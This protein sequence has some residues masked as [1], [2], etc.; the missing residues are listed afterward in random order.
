MKSVF[1]SQSEQESH[2]C[3]HHAREKKK[4]LVKNMFEEILS[5][6]KKTK[7]PNKQTKKP[8]LN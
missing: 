7:K 4:K 5:L 1:V 2:R 3:A 8:P 6:S